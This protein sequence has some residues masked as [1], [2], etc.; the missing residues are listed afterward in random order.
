MTLSIGL[1]AALSGLATTSDQT[2]VVSRNVARAG[3]PGASRKIANL[4]TLPGG[5]VKLASITRVSN[6]AL[7]DKLLGAT[8]DAGARQAIADALNRLDGTVN[9]PELDASPAALVGKLADAIQRYAAA[10]QDAAAARSAV[11]AASDLAQALN[12]ATRATQQLRAEADADIAGSVDRVNTLLAQFATVNAEIVKGTRQGADVTDYLDHRDQILAGI[13][14][15]VGVRTVTRA[16]NDMAV[17]TD[18]GVTLFDVRPRAVGFDRTLQFMPTTSGNAVYIDGVPVAGGA[19]PMLAGSGRLT[20][21]VAVRDGVAV[22][23]QNQL[24]EI[25]RGLIQA[26]A[27]SD[28]SAT[29]TLPDAPGLFTYAGAPAMPPGGSVLTGLAGTIRV[30]A[31]VDPAQGGNAAR[32]RDGGISGNP[33]YLYNAAGASAYTQR[34]EEL[35]ERLNAPMAFDAAAQAA[36]SGTVVGFAAS[37]VSWLQEA[38]KSADADN[39]Y[40][41]TLKDRAS[42]ALSKATG[43]NLDEEMAMLLELERSY[44]ASTK[45]VSTIDNMLG[46]L[47]QVAG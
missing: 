9:D 22:T 37:S 40:K 2:S 36:P 21:L 14:E 41:A 38:R 6:A 30:S 24:D 44:Q 10:P 5:G 45:L 25:A 20:G 31:S 18:S 46:A 13:A 12:D 8:S 3:E 27:E 33:A 42:E 32:L 15:E 47:L 28:Q 11:A 4:V 1:D 26:F 34:L 23:Y 43:V 16:D 17:F 19:G 29:P 35:L 7:Y 39:E